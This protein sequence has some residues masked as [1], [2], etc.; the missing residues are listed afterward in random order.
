MAVHDRPKVGVVDQKWA[1]SV[2]FRARFARVNTIFYF[3][4]VSPLINLATMTS[5]RKKVLADESIVCCMFHVRHVVSYLAEKNES[6]R[7]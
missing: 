1:W 4:P 5:C 2:N 6:S 3:V 7:L